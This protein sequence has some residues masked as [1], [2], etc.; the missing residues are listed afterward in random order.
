M[1]PLKVIFKTI[2]FSGVENLHVRVFL[3]CSLKKIF[4]ILCLQWSAIAD[5]HS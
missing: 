5:L 1:Y 3:S 4:L 2:L